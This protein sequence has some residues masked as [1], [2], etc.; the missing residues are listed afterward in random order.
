MKATRTLPGLALVYCLMALAVGDTSYSRPPDADRTPT[1]KDTLRI[2]RA[3]I[4]TTDAWRDVTAFLRQ[5]LSG[6]TLSV[7]MRSRSRK[8]AATQHL[9]R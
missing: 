4:G 1:T 9:E 8:L 7:T 6:D 3:F 2:E 5:H